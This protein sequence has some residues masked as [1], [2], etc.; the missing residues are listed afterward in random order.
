MV[1]LGRISV[2]AFTLHVLVLLCI[3]LYSSF[4]HFRCWLYLLMVT[5][6][7]MMTATISWVTVQI[8]RSLQTSSTI[9]C[10]T[11]IYIILYVLR[12]VR[13]LF[14]YYFERSDTLF[15]IDLIILFWDLL[16]A[17]VRM[18]IH[19]MKLIFPISM[20]MSYLLVETVFW[21]MVS[22]VFII[23]CD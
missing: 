3:R 15:Y 5:A 10:D 1:V 17:C 13:T 23:R 11:S 22:N 12:D 14:M 8:S 4:Y 9:S 18:I 6:L 2:L 20:F 16:G 19:L 21:K 7:W